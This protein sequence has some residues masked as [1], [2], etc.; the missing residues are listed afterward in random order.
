[1]PQIGIFILSLLTNAQ[2][3]YQFSP[4]KMLKIS[5]AVALLLCLFAV[6]GEWIKRNGWLLR[7]Y[8]KV[9]FHAK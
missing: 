9:I 3:F 2:R 7:L 8:E 6:L 5:L 1:M 4:K